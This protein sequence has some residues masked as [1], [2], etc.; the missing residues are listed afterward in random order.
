M[1]AIALMVPARAHA[2][3][4]APEPEPG[5]IEPIDTGALW[6]EANTRL[7][8][9]DYAGAIE[10]LTRLYD[11]VARDPD[12]RV[13]RLRVR[14]TLH[15]AH[16]GAYGVDHDA[17]HLYVARDLLRKAD[18]D[19]GDADAEL[20]AQHEA[21]IAELD[22]RIAEIEEAAA[23]AEAARK[24]EADRAAAVAPKRAEPSPPPPVAPADDRRSGRPLVVAGGVMLGVGAVGIGMLVGGLASANAAV[25][26]F[27]QEPEQRADARADIRRGNALGIAGGV[28]AGV[29]LT[30]GA[31]LLAIGLRRG[32]GARKARA[33]VT[34]V[35]LGLVCAGRF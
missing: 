16:L 19:F 18:A 9:S 31:S 28:V 35:P 29:L 4:A 14:W 7:E 5:A 23:A 3:P 32:G 20:R 17:Q 11:A 25:G 6:R 1:L 8:T 12:A 13:L 2:G 26:V 15:E 33:S 22:R 34:P 30:T 27:E 24:A 10:L 21:A